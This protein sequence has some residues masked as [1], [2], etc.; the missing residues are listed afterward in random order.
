MYVSSILSKKWETA[1][2][3]LTTEMTH[4]CTI[5]NYLR[6]LMMRNE[7]GGEGKLCE[8]KVRVMIDP[9]YNV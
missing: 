2:C 8:K 9:L 1:M 5:Y 7:L 4:V 6:T 3:E